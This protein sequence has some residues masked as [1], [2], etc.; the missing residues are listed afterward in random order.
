VCDVAD[1]HQ[2]EPVQHLVGL[3]AHPTTADVERVQERGHRLRRDHD[4]PSGGRR[5]ASGDRDGARHR[6]RQVILLS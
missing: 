3:L 6:P 5:L 1:R 2:S 4:H